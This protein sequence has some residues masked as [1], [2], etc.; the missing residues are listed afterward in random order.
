MA[1]QK[2]NV[3]IRVGAGMAEDVDAFLLE[4][5]KALEL[6]NARFPHAG[7]V[8]KRYG[9]TALPSSGD[10]A[11]SSGVATLL[12]CNGSLFQTHPDGS[13]V[14]DST[15]GLW[16]DLNISAPR[17]S[18]TVS[19]PLVRVNS[20]LTCPDMAIIDGL[21]LVVWQDEVSEGIGYAF[22]DAETRTMLSPAATLTS[23]T[24]Q[25]PKVIAQGTTFVLVAEDT[26]TD[27]AVAWAYSSAGSTLVI[28]DSPTILVNVNDWIW[29]LAPC[30]DTAW[31]AIS[32]L[33]G[34]GND[35]SLHRFAVSGFAAGATASVSGFKACCL[36]YNAGNDKLVMGDRDG[37]IAHID[38]DFSP[39]TITDVG[40]VLA[41]D[42]TTA[43]VTD[44]EIVQRDSSGGMW[45]LI[46]GYDGVY[47]TSTSVL[48]YCCFRRIT[49]SFATSGSQQAVGMRVAGKGLYLGAEQEDALI[50][51][52]DG[53]GPSPWV[54]ICRLEFDEDSEAIPI[55]V[56]TALRDKVDKLFDGLYDQ[57]G[58]GTFDSHLSTPALVGSDAVFLFTT[59]V[60]QRGDDPFTDTVSGGF[61]RQADLVRVN[62]L[63]AP[64]QRNV[65]AQGIRII[66]DG[67]GLSS[68]DGAR[69][70]EL[71]P[72]SIYGFEGTAN[73]AAPN[74]PVSGIP[75]AD[76]DGVDTTLAHRLR[77]FWRYVDAQGNIHRGPPSEEVSFSPTTL[78][79]GAS[80]GN[81]NAYRLR[82]PKPITA[83]DGQRGVKL[84]LEAALSWED[85][86]EDEWYFAGIIQPIEDPGQPGAVYFLVTWDGS[87]E[88]HHL[89]LTTHT[90]L[91]SRAQPYWLTEL[92]AY[93]TGPLL[94]ICSTQ[95][96]LWAISGED[97]LTVLP[98]KPIEQ[99]VAPEFATELAIRIPSEGGD[100]VGIAAL[101][102]KIVVFKER[103]IYVL[104][105]EPG[106]AAG[107]NSSIAPPRLVPADSGCIAAASIVNVGD[108]GVA[109]Q[110]ERGICLLTPGLTVER[111]GEAV[112]DSLNGDVVA[113][114]ATMVPSES[115]V[116]WSTSSGEVYVWNYR[117]DA[118]AVWDLDVLSATMWTG[119]YGTTF[120]YLDSDNTPRRE[121][122]GDWDDGASSPLS[123]ATPWLQMAGKQGIQRVWR[124]ISLLRYYENGLNIG[125]AY[126]FN[127]AEPTE[128]HEFTQAALAALAPCQV[129]IDPIRPKCEAIRLVFTEMEAEGDG[130]EGGKPP[131]ESGRGFELIGVDLTCGVKKGHYRNIQADGG[132]G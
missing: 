82:L 114:T 130:G 34:I 35:T 103:Q 106:D 112:K 61:R 60:E 105:G 9:T 74:M 116:R 27:N 54:D 23:S 13:I 48:P 55:R 89:G 120:A 80:G 38:A 14:L 17:P 49:S 39:A 11:T 99:G 10:F 53:G 108:R 77:V 97:R 91:V 85:A 50:P 59:L 94:D 123:I 32:R 18:L 127:E 28:T 95:G 64:A 7:A 122:P 69:H 84:E 42:I 52:W 25:T 36:R 57:H 113:L 109:F 73:A 26:A 75:Y 107:D 76:P 66:A 24:Y 111:I 102:D 68:I 87:P 110:S 47:P 5:P 4:S 63:A 20:P 92:H 101:E 45:M 40:Q 71:A 43:E 104:L 126:D 31:F 41:P 100:C 78:A 121:T 15:Y 51:F 72:P 128:D 117:F 33:T 118:W 81:V 16:R 125:V 1:L 46:S 131:P 44:V 22:F 12:E 132:K 79:T 56:A 119:T 90:L 6:R 83:L 58:L 98:S 3:S 129:S 2:Q 62:H 29:D 93:P 115:E 88:P 8:G 30:A 65:T 67:T 96:R 19:D 70:G 124:L 86:G 21:M 37:G